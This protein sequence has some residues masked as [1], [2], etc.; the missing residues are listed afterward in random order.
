[1][2]LNY[3]LPKKL[4]LLE[5]ALLLYKIQFKSYKWL[6]L[7]HFKHLFATKNLFFRT[8]LKVAMERNKEGKWRKRG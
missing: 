2:F 4:L 8:F 7:P 6:A 1:M 5:S 3:V